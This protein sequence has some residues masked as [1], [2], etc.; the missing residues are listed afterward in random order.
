MSYINRVCDDHI[1]VIPDKDAL[2]AFKPIN[3]LYVLIG[4]LLS[5]GLAILIYVLFSQLSF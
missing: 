2:S 5:F 4:T 1:G 3:V